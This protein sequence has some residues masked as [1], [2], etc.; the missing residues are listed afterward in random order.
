MRKL[1]LFAAL[2]SFIACGSK[3]EVK[4]NTL[5]EK[6]VKD[7]WVLLFDGQSLNGW[8]GYQNKSTPGWKAQNGELVCEG[9]TEDKSDMRTDLVTA[10]QF[11]N[12]ELVVDWKIT[13]Q[14]NSG[15]LYLVGEDFS[16]SWMT[17]PEYQIIDDNDFPEPLE[18]WQKTAGN[19]AMILLK[20]WNRNL[21]ANGT[22]QK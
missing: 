7:G 9:S 4:D 3:T 10:E 8:R 17:G 19:Y 11:D 14:S 20:K 6:E 5:T 2:F 22:I 16:A 15:I 18:D 1:I 21:W 13:P 12:F